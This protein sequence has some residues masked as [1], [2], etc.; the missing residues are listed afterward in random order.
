M[1]HNVTNRIGSRLINIMAGI[2]H[3]N[4]VDGRSLSIY[5]NPIT[6]HNCEMPFLPS[7]K[8]K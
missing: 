6:T 2:V 3:A 4:G 8:R 5:K 7:L 1:D